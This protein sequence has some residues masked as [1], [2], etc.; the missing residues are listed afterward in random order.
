MKYCAEKNF[1]QN[2]TKKLT[3]IAIFYYLSSNYSKT[4]YAK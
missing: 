2:D 4:W 3:K 1:L